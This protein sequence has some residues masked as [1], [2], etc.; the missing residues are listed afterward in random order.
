MRSLKNIVT[1]SVVFILLFVFSPREVFSQVDPSA[2]AGQ[3]LSEYN[4]TDNDSIKVERLFDLAF[5]YNDYLADRKIADSLSETA[6]RLAEKSHRP[7]LLFLGYNR[8][9]ESN[10]LHENYQKALGYALKAA[11]ISFIGK[12]SGLVFRNYKNLVSVYL[13]GYEF[14]KAL[15]YSYK[16]LSI[17][18]TSENA[19][20]KA[21][22]YLYI[23]QSLEGKN[24]KIEA[25]RNYLNAMS[26]AERVRNSKL[27]GECC[28]RLS[29]FYN[30]NKL[31][32]KATHYKLVERDLIQNTKPVDSVALMWTEYDLQV[33]DI[34]SNN[35]QLY[36]GNMEEIL[37]FAMRNKHKRLMNY[38]IGLIR[39]HYI[40]ANK[41]G[42]LHRMYD[43]KFP[44][45]LANLEKENPALFFRL[46]GFFYEEENMPDSA[47]YYF[48]QA[49]KLLVSDPNI[50][51]QSN[52][53]NRFGQF[54]MRHGYQEKAI[55][56]FERSFEL[57]KT[58]SYFDYMLGA[59]KQLEDI[60]A[61]RG[62]YKQAFTYSV[63]NKVLSDSLNNMSKKDQL[64]IMEIDHETRQ[65]ELAAEQEE[66]STIRRHYLQY[67]AITIGIL[68]AFVLLI[69][70][71]SLKVPEWI[72]RML[73]FFSFIFLFEF[74]IL[75]ADHRIEEITHGEPW[76][77]LLIK[78]FLIAILLPLHHEIEKRV[79]TYLLN[80]KLIDMSRFSVVG[81]I[82]K[83][84]GKWASGRVG[85]WTHGDNN[86]S[87]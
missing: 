51:L 57:A 40:E 11:Q 9:I 10:D 80:H 35:N 13:S 28:A 24:Q 18:A 55:E 56:K 81:R 85:R 41:I 72:I 45:E 62:D 53:Y 1:T 29:N 63:L 60:Y 58:A 87:S 7:E 86:T 73:G 76:K 47:L 83:K 44:M 48:N 59:A 70:L 17:A 54:L 14:D 37:N 42:L 49:E 68:S 75:L 69:M 43:K 84:V 5:F 74:I 32:T 30:F 38:E 82:R 71:G 2:F 67:T 46:N 4:Q 16:L 23:G 78:I 12:N 6:I 66:Q 52:F 36:E 31:Y 22:S 65:R 61:I 39:T 3:I 27:R 64:L 20:M 8:Y 50:I 77:V 34:N 21:E 26:L 19:A 15:E 79:I 33:I 25:F